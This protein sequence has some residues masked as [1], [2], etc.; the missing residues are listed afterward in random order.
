MLQLQ[1]NSQLKSRL[2][3]AEQQLLAFRSAAGY[4]GAARAPE[5]TLKAEDV[6]RM[7]VGGRG[8]VCQVLLWQLAEAA[9][10]A[11]LLFALLV[12][13]FPLSVLQHSCL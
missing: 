2:A 6:Q 8:T 11:A 13:M 10:V 12:W 7:Q 4:A 9:A 1:E 5:A 3:A